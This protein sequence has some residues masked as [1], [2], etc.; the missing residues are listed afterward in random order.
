M[1]LQMG[2]KVG[3][4]TAAGYYEATVTRIDIKRTAKPGL[5][6]NFYLMEVD[7]YFTNKVGSRS[8]IN[9]FMLDGLKVREIA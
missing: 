5:W 6:A 1:K 2:Q 7:T 4:T 3:L 9:E 8:Y